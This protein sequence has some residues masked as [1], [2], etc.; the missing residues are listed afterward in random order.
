MINLIFK[1]RAFLIVKKLEV[2]IGEVDNRHI[3]GLF[4]LNYQN[5]TI[6]LGYMQSFGSTG[7]PF[8]SGTESP[9][10]L[11][12]MSSDYSN[13]DEKVYSIRYEYDFKMRR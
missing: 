12:F 2:K 8:L 1:W 11:D 9:V 5:H 13:K 7:L 4:G 10:V 3:S 6:S